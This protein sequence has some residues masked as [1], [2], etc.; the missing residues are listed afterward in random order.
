MSGSELRDP[1]TLALLE[2]VRDG[3]ILNVTPAAG[4][5]IH[6]F[7]NE[8]EWTKRGGFAAPYLGQENLISAG[9]RRGGPN[10]SPGSA[11]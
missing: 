9:K 5:G 3:L 11:R 6:F 10:V 2:Q 1:K 4:P 7:E 8:P